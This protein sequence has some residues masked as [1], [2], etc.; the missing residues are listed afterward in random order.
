[1]WNVFLL[2]TFCANSNY[3]NLLGTRITGT[4][5][6]PRWFAAR[7]PTRP[8]VYLAL[9][10]WEEEKNN[11]SPQIYGRKAIVKP[12]RSL[13]FYVKKRL[14]KH[15]AG[16]YWSSVTLRDGGNFHYR[17][18]PAWCE[19]YNGSIRMSCHCL[20]FSKTQANF[21]KLHCTQLSEP[22]CF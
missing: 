1:M 19:I 20:T 13:V 9:S 12:K 10:K 17:W 2:S 21:T 11:F 6:E 7:T 8:N 22:T 14:D 16:R 3:S 4:P 15:F 18:S 5:L